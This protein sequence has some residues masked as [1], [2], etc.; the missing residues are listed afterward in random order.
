MS[1]IITDNLRIL[2]AKQFV[3]TAA[4]TNYYSFIGLPNP[5]DYSAD[6]NISPLAPKDSFEQE[7]DYWDTM[8]ALKKIFSTDVRQAVRKIRWESGITYDMYRHDISRTK[9]AVPSGATS[10][11][12][13][14]Y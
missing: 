14:N 5:S 9:T 12:S 1:A 3:E 13:S 4:T 7:S 11:Y 10:L 8:I 2:R 6:W